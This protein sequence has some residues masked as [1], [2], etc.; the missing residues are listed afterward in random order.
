MTNTIETVQFP[1]LTPAEFRR[2]FQVPGCAVIIQ[3]A[4]DGIAEWNLESLADALGDTRYAAR[5]YG[6]GHFQTPRQEWTRY[7]EAQMVTAHEYAGMLSDRSAHRENVYLAQIDIG[8]TS[9]ATGI[10]EHVEALGARC[11]M[12]RLVPSDINLWLGPSGH[13][14]PLHFDTGDGTLMQL[15]GSKRV[16]LFPP[17]QTRN[18]YP[19]PFAKGPIPPWFSQVD[20]AQPDFNRFPRL[21]TALNNAIVVT[22]VPGDVLYIPVHW[23]HEV[24]ALGDS[25]VCSLNR[26]WEARPLRRNFCNWR[27]GALYSMNHVPWRVVMAIDRCI[28]T[29]RERRW[30]RAAHSDIDQ[31]EQSHDD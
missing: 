2:R 10:R 18:L 14:E 25:Y 6:E 12:R 26:F 20:V 29:V 17:T 7:A 11:D 19:F 28:R 23:W 24:T 4:L 27:A 22:I 21:R 13:T 1:D 5:R 30:R 8:G 16:L 15:H 31:L 3:G 9:A